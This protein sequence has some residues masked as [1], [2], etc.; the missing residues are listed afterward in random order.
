MPNMVITRTASALGRTFRL[1]KTVSAD[2]AVTKEPPLP[3]AKAGTLSTR[4]SDTAGTLTLGTGH[5][6]ASDTKLDVYWSN[7]TRVNVTVGTVAGNAVPITS[8]SGD[9]LPAQGAA[10]TVMAPHE[11]EWVV[12]AANMTGLAVGCSGTPCVARFV[13]SED[14]D[15]A[16]IVVNPGDQDF[17]WADGL[18]DNPITDD[19]VKVFLTHASSTGTRRPIATAMID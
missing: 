2:G 6:V 18:G 14:A 4:S 9:N 8:G 5:G 11:E 12:T 13:D 3:A 7:G 10:V 1:D 19:V 16:T 17:V 15:V